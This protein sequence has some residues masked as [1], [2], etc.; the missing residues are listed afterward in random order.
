MARPPPGFAAGS[1]E[2]LSPCYLHGVGTGWMT[3]IVA[4]IRIMSDSDVL[5]VILTESTTP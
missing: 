3:S 5:L 4:W 2:T 1:P